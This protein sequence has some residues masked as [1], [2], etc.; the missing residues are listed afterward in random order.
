MLSKKFAPVLFGLILSGMMSLLVSAIAT[1]R[2]IGMTPDFVTTWITGW[3]T[4][5]A[6][7]FPIVLVVAPLA[8]RLVH[9]LLVRA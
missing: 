6:I 9:R 8:Q 3:L 4:A 2:A 5:W 7:A 1:F